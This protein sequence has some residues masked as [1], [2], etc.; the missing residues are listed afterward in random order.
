M[1]VFSY[2]CVSFHARSGSMRGFG[3]AG[4][5]FRQFFTAG[6]RNSLLGPVPMGMGMKSPMMGYPAPR[7]YHQHAR[8]Y[9]NNNNNTPTTASSSFS[10]SSS[11]S[12]SSTTTAVITKAPL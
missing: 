3:M 8:Y 4:Q 12:S 5:Q 9:N 10:S 2:Q 1:C 7:Q 11:S 6:S